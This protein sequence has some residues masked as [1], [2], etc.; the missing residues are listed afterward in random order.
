MQKRGISNCVPSHDCS[1]NLC[2]IGVSKDEI[3]LSCII[4]INKLLCCL[5]T[6]SL[7]CFCMVTS[8][9]MPR[10]EPTCP[11]ATCRDADSSCLPHIA[12]HQI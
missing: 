10:K 5:H 7:Y 2:M 12:A 6:F 9:A 4:Y 11:V 8:G 1:R 3:E